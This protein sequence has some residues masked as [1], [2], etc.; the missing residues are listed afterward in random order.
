M[1]HIGSRDQLSLRLLFETQS[2]PRLPK[3]GYG[4]DSMPDYR[5]YHIMQNRFVGV[6]N[7]R[8]EDDGHALREARH[9]NGSTSSELWEG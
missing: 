2:P 6:D 3:R 5:L 4:G 8:A 7:F 9:L 1:L